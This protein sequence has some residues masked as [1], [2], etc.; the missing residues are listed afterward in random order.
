MNELIL[1]CLNIS[2]CLLLAGYFNGKMDY[3]KEYNLDKDT[4]I[5]KYAK[6][7]LPYVK[8]W[9]Y[10]GLHTPKYAEAFPF[11]STGLVWLTDKWHTYKFL[12]FLFCEFPIVFMFVQYNNLLWELI[13]VG[14]ICIKGFRGLGFKISYDKKS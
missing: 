1:T 5:N 4:W 8:K 3:I 6:G 13:P 7:E 14:I 11:S 12:T 10:L 9:Y 2:F